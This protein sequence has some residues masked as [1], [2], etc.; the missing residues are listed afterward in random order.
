MGG[1]GWPFLASRWRAGPLLVAALALSVVAGCG[2]DDAVDADDGSDLTPAQQTI[3]AGC[4]PCEVELEPRV[5]ITDSAGQGFIH[6]SIPMVRRDRTGRYYAA[7][8]LSAELLVFDSSGVQVDLIGRGG[9]GPGEFEWVIPPT[10]GPGDSLLVW[11]GLLR[12]TAVYSPSL[13]FVRDYRFPF[14]PVYVFEDGSILVNRNIPDPDHIGYPLHLLAPDGEIL[15]SFGQDP[16]E[17]RADRAAAYH[18]ALAVTGEGQIWTSPSHRL[19]PELWDPWTGERI[20]ELPTEWSEF[21]IDESGGQEADPR[22]YRPSTRVTG[23]I[24]EPEGVLWVLLRDAAPDWEADY[25]PDEPIPRRGLSLEEYER[26]YDWVVLAV[27]DTSGAILG[28]ARF[29]HMVRGLSGSDFF[30]SGGRVVGEHV[31]VE[32]WEPLLVPPDGSVAEP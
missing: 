19:E 22:R 21:T 30:K 23:L 29:P 11:D 26:L 3:A 32:I 8:Q 9:Q 12:R 10:V 27:D 14:S 1:S 4:P 2:S 13:E 24:H 6:S 15:R 7:P 16:P 20:H 28:E 25:G 5:V 31:E 18:R 17:F